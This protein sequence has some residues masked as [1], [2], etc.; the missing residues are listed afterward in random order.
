MELQQDTP[1]ETGWFW[2]SSRY[3]SPKLCRFISPDDVEYLDAESVNGLNLYCYC[4]NDPINYYDPSGCEPITIGAA[5]LAI[6][7]L[8]ALLALYAIA[9]VVCIESETHII[10]NSFTS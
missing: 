4:L 8:I 1:V 2:L 3:Y 6:Y 7:A 10:Q 9:N 5:S